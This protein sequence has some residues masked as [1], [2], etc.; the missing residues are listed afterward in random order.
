MFNKAL[1]DEVEALKREL[2]GL[3]AAQQSRSEHQLDADAAL[4]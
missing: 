4:R 3:R 1:R 2:H